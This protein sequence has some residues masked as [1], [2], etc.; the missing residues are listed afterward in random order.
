MTLRVDEANLAG[1]SGR[2][3]QR[4]PYRPPGMRSPLTPPPTPRCRL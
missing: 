4:D 2:A 1:V 3:G